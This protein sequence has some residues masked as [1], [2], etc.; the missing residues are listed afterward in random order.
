MESTEP[1]GREGWEPTTR[2]CTLER[3]VFPQF[4]TGAVYCG[5]TTAKRFTPKDI[6][7]GTVVKGVWQMLTFTFDKDTAG[8]TRRA[9]IATKAGMPVPVR[10]AGFI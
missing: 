3:L 2:A 7:S 8:S 9:L 6:P 5:V 4:S 1:G 10:Y